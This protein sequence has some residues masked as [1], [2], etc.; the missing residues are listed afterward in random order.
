MREQLRQRSS[1][2]RAKAVGVVEGVALTDPEGDPSNSKSSLVT[3]HACKG[4][5][6]LLLILEE[7]VFILQN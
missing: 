3:P 2:G 7:I 4:G 6:L 5:L 1:R